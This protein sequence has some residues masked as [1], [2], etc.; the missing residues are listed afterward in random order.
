MERIINE[1]NIFTF[2]KRTNMV[3]CND[4]CLIMNGQLSLTIEHIKHIINT[5]RAGPLGTCHHR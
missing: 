5:T 2:N 1:Y 4:I 3:S